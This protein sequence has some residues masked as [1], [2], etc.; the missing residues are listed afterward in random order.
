MG[1]GHFARTIN[2]LK[3]KTTMLFIAHIL[4]KV[5]LLDGVVRFE[6]TEKLRQN[7]RNEKG[8]GWTV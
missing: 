6:E 5:L 7:E 8:Q 2:R 4:P 1:A 3:G